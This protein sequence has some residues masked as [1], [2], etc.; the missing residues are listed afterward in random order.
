MKF[1]KTNIEDK[2]KDIVC[3]ELGHAMSPVAER[4]T[5]LI[6]TTL[7][8]Y[9]DVKIVVSTVISEGFDFY[10]IQIDACFVEDKFDY[11]AKDKFTECCGLQVI[12]KFD[13]EQLT[14]IY[15]ANQKKIF[16]KRDGEIGSIFIYVNRK[17][18][19]CVDETKTNII[20]GE[21]NA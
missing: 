5:L 13:T 3:V 20:E 16:A 17:H 11:F 1:K 15:A 12:K 19:Q 9:E 10:R 8:I 6:R 14:N 21:Y 2:K 18:N 7:L 4:K